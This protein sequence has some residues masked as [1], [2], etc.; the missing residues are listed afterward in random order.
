MGF[1]R[2]YMLVLSERDVDRLHDSSIPL[3]RLACQQHFCSVKAS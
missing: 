2:V 1:A 3:L